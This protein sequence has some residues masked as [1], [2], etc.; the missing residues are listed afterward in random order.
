MEGVIVYLFFAPIFA[1]HSPH[2]ST[3]RNNNKRNPSDFD[4]NS[5]PPPSTMPEL[6]VNE[7]GSKASDGVKV[8]CST[9]DEGELRRRAAGIFL[10]RIVSEIV[11]E[12]K[13]LEEKR[14]NKKHFCDFSNKVELCFGYVRHYDCVDADKRPFIQEW[15][16]WINV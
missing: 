16:C 13:S 8:S 11:T 6:I 14:A 10:E 2:T 7:E 12:S 1:R 5:F 9:K 3:R 15:R 4:L